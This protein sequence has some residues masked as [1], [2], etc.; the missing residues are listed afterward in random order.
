MGR[1]M[2]SIPFGPGCGCKGNMCECG[3]NKKF[4]SIDE[5]LAEL[6]THIC[7]LYERLNKAEEYITILLENKR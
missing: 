7:L 5:K 3:L 6:E 4:K 2:N 1:Q